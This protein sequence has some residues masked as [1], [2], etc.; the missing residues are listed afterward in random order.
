MIALAHKM[1]NALYYIL[2]NKEDYSEP[3]DTKYQKKGKQVQLKKFLER[4][5]ELGVKVY[6]RLNW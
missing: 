2:K 4:I 5:Q 1:P 6:F 3:D